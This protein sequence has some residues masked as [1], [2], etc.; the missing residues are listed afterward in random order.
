MF[1]NCSLGAGRSYNGPRKVLIFLAP[2][3]GFEPVTC[4]LGSLSRF[5]L[6]LRGD[7]TAKVHK[8]F[9]APLSAGDERRQE[10]DV[11]F[12]VH[13]KGDIHPMPTSLKLLS[14]DTS[15]FGRAPLVIS[16]C[17]VPRYFQLDTNSCDAAA[18]RWSTIFVGQWTNT[19]ASLFGL[20]LKFSA[21]WTFW[22]ASVVAHEDKCFGKQ[23]SSISRSSSNPLTPCRSNEVVDDLC[24]EFE[25]PC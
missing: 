21:S 5:Q 11:H 15:L 20:R 1:P 3:T 18:V 8:D 14:D 2:P 6:A 10:G 12:S 22:H 17:P 16:P 4:G 9:R 24:S 19:L 13:S 7:N 23:L 25:L